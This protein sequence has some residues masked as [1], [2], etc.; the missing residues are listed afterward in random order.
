MAIIKK[1]IEP[2]ISLTFVHLLISV[3]SPTHK[4]PSDYIDGILELDLE[5][6]TQ[7]QRKHL[8]PSLLRQKIEELKISENRY[9][10]ISGKDTFLVTRKIWD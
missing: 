5:N 7:V 2:T 4:T 10:K 6:G 1:K 8:S 3:V 9:E